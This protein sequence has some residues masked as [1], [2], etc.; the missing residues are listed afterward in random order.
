MHLDLHYLPQ[1][2]IIGV[3]LT[4]IPAPI[5]RLVIMGEDTPP[6]FKRL[7]GPEWQDFQLINNE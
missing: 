5:R 6:N 7:F 2:S 1:V 4:G 3:G